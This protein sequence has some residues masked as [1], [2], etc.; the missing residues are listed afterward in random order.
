MTAALLAA[1][2]TAFDRIEAA[3]ASGDLLRIGD[4][5]PEALRAC[6]EL[7]AAAQDGA[8]DRV[9]LAR[10][11]RRAAV[12]S[13]RLAAAARGVADAIRLL[14]VP[15][16]SATVYDARGVAQ[17]LTSAGPQMRRRM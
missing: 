14:A 6:E 1:A 7:V 11:C 10:L 2:E 13:A 8:A 12:L 9:R 5:A 17:T 16:A 3:F 4:E 15:V